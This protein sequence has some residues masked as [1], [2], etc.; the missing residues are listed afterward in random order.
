MKI[1]RRRRRKKNAKLT[2]IICLICLR[3]VL[4]AVCI[5]AK[6]LRKLRGLWRG[7]IDNDTADYST[8]VIHNHHD[9]IG[10]IDD[11]SDELDDGTVR[12]WWVGW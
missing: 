11:D 2:T 8:G 6:K 12:E 4:F 7:Y 5:S 3:G 1:Q 10:G 9:R